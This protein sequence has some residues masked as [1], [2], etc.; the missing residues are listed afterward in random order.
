MRKK[1][2]A[3]NWKMNKTFSDAENFLITLDEELSERYLQHVKVIVCTPYPYLELA[4]DQAD[5]GKMFVGAQDVSSHDFGAYTGEVSAPMLHSMGIDYC[6]IGHSER[7]KYHQ[8]TDDIINQKLKQLLANGIKPILCIGE[9]LTERENNITKKIIK[10]Q[11]EGCCKGI[12][13]DERITIAYEPVWAIGTGKTATPQQAQEIHAFIRDWIEQ[14]SSTRIAED[15]AI[16][17]GG[18]M[19]PKNTAEL[20]QQKDID[21]GLIGG[22]SLKTESFVEMIDIAITL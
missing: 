22:A 8:E 6:I 14:N 16:L 15:I 10:K 12:E 13:L 19:K 17:Y 4:F 20:L 5:S 9:T 1:I 21:G 7:R 11:L 2:I 18:S 3:G